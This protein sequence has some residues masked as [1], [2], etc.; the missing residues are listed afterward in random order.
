[1]KT[2]VLKVNE[3]GIRKAVEV[4]E[5]GG[6]IVYPTETF[7]GIGADPRNE[8][9]IERIFQIKGRKRDMPILL[10]IG[11]RDMLYDLVKEI[12]DVGNKLMNRFWPGPLTIIFQANENVSP[13]LHA[14]KG[15]IGIRLSGNP[16]SRKLSELSK[17]PITGTSANRSGRPPCRTVEEILSELRGVDLVLD[18]GRIDSRLPSTV[19]DVTEDPPKIIREGIVSKEEIMD[20][21]GEEYA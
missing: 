19:I 16:I 21:I 10:I 9:A 18:S 5:K 2:E 1:M 20:C 13:L 12:P 4:I 15:K 14:G 11:K 6:I 3:E 7:Y 8:E 17:I